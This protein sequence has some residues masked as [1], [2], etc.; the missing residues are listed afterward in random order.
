MPGR[1]A[2]K[3]N[4]KGIASISPAVAW[5][6]LPWVGRRERSSTPT[7]LCP[8][9]CV[10]S[11]NALASTPLE[12]G[13]SVGREPKVAP[14]SQPW[15]GGQN[16]VGILGGG[17]RGGTDEIHMAAHQPGERRLEAVFSVGAQQL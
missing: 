1:E 14:A 4:P 8:E 10:G 13:V 17:R 12:L 15:A 2:A 9:S 7:G 11:E 6:E 3:D 16:P 5:N